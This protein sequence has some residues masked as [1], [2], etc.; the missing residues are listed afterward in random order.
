M[1]EMIISNPEFNRMESS[2]LELESGIL[3]SES[4][5]DTVVFEF[6]FLN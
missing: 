3:L 4:E 5:L 6:Y 1:E 2:L